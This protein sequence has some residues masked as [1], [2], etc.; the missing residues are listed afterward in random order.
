MYQTNVMDDSRDSTCHSEFPV[1]VLLIHKQ[2]ENYILSEKFNSHYSTR[3]GPIF[4]KK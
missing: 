4:F 2:K 3:K 1:R